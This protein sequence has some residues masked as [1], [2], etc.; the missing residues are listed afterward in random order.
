M[1]G[2]RLKLEHKVST[3][4]NKYMHAHAKNKNKKWKERKNESLTFFFH[5]ITRQ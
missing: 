2:N 1:F 4:N 3:M 5:N